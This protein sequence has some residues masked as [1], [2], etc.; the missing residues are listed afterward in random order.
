MEA[1]LKKATIKVG[2]KGWWNPSTGERFMD[3]GHDYLFY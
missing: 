1:I 2:S 3:Q